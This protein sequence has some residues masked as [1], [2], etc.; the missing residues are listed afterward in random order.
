MD[1]SFRTRRR[2]SIRRKILLGFVA[3]ISLLALASLLAT[4]QNIRNAGIV[5]NLDTDV[6]PDTL[7]FIA[8]ETNTLRI[9]QWMTYAALTQDPKGL[10]KAEKYFKEADASI[11]LLIK[12]AKAEGDGELADKLVP[13]KSDLEDFV[14]LG[15]QMAETYMQSGPEIGNAMMESFNPIAEGIAVA[16]ESF[17]NERKAAMNEDFNGLLG[18]FDFSVMTSIG[19]VVLSCISGLIIA[20]AI[21]GSISRSVG[22]IA[23]LAKRMSEGNLSARA[24]LNTGDELGALANNLN[25]AISDIKDLVDGAKSLAAEND[26]AAAE[27]KAKVNGAKSAATG[28]SLNAGQVSGNFESLLAAI[29]GSV[30]RIAKIFESIA[31]M[32]AQISEQ[33]GA[34]TETSSAI[35]EMS[36]ALRN[37]DRIIG[38]RKAMSAKLTEI[39]ANGGEKVAATNNSIGSVSKKIE[40]IVE[41]ME[42]IRSISSQTNLLAM[43]ASIEA[44]HAGDFGKGFAVVADEIRR[45]AETTAESTRG[46]TSSLGELISDIESA[47]GSSGES[48]LAFSSINSEVRE[49]YAALEEI[50]RSSYELAKGGSEISQAM[51]SLLSLTESIKTGFSSIDAE[52]RSIE[53]SLEAVVATSEKSREDLR[54]IDS[55]TTLL[56]GDVEL[57]SQLTT[58]S[59]S[60]IQKLNEEIGVF[61]TEA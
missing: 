7:A 6:L 16:M 9:Q 20:L 24:A 34:V 45:L 57:I 50:S 49:V 18:S 36:A 43:N 11:S 61:K 13:L 14:S 19:A 59:H 26:K 22:K 31:E 8:L 58:K 33:A 42:M 28:I 27:L 54:D 17:V 51:T 25:A 52:A 55:K 47:L 32:K 53:S 2:F 41:L 46:V 30:A 37:V 39:T 35:E 3:V 40:L 1:R 4:F 15:M 10:E 48:G 29:E 12:Q 60:D 23:D 56:D 44:A 38:E 5:N 21:S